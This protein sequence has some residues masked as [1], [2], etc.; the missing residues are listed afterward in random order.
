MLLVNSI[1]AFP[2]VTSCVWLEMFPTNEKLAS[3]S[4]ARCEILNCL[5]GGKSLV[6]LS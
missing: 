2:D 3:D 1:S 6:N 5:Q 4:L